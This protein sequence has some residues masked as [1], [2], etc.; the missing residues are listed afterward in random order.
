MVGRNNYMS[1]GSGSGNAPKQNYTG[2]TSA[3]M[4]EGGGMLFSGGEYG[5]PATGEKGEGRVHSPGEG[6]ET[7]LN[8]TT[9][10]SKLRLS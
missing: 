1:G 8:I 10:E 5:S 3:F 7:L 9:E 4:S 6:R 2:G